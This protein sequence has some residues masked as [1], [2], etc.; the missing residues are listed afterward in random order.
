VRDATEG[1]ASFTAGPFNCFGQW[2]QVTSTDGELI[3]LFSDLYAP[4]L[5]EPTPQA[6][7]V[8]YRL[9]PPI[10][11]GRG[12]VYRDGHLLGGGVRP[13]RVMA[14]VIWGINRQIID[15]TSD[16]LLLH[17]AAAADGTGRVVLLPAA[18]EAGKT[19]LVTGLLDRGLAYLTD[20]AAAVR[21]DLTVQGFAKPLSIDTGSW[22]LLRHHRPHLAD[23]LAPYMSEQWQV[24]PHHFTT[25]LDEGSLALIVFPSYRT[26]APTTFERLDAIDALD[27]ARASTFGR[28]GRPLPVDRLAGLAEVVTAVP[29]YELRS[30]DLTEA[31]SRVIAALEARADE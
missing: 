15:N 1:G 18:M 12:A 10:E 11:G 27:L 25:V 7:V 3:R 29:C 24:P 6:D 17:A 28:E 19:T 4:M 16:R 31:C 23:R 5:V 13:A 30:G 14:K 20:E 21:P 2:W 9:V 22:S 26:G 8:E